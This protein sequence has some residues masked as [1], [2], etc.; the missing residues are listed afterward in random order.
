MTE[1]AVHEASYRYT[2]TDEGAVIDRYLGSDTEI[3]VPE[4]LG[5][6]PVIGIAPRAFLREESAPPIRRLSLPESLTVLGDGAL[7]GFS[8]EQ[9]RRGTAAFH[10]SL[11]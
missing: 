4:T 11:P 2:L 7:A 8:A 6:L 3:T 10:A 9:I 1:T 5:G